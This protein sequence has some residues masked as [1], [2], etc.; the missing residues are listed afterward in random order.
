MFYSFCTR[1]CHQNVPECKNIGITGHI[2]SGG[3]HVF[4][5]AGR[6]HL[7]PPVLR[8]PG[9]L[10]RV[11]PL[12]TASRGGAAACRSYMGEAEISG[13]GGRAPDLTGPALQG[14]SNQRDIT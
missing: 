7:L 14:K 8:Y 12:W 13:A 11:Q 5:A 4:Q 9:C 2:I 1:W 3:V 10:Q 6:H